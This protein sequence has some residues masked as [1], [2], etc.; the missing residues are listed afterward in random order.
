MESCINVVRAFPISLLSSLLINSKYLPARCNIEIIQC[1]L[2]VSTDKELQMGNSWFDVRSKLLALA[3]LT[4][5]SLSLIQTF[6]VGLG[7]RVDD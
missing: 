6:S 3:R 7:R 5:L 2:P 1:K 4:S